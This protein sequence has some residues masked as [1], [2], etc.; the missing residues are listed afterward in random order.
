M[1][2][3]RQLRGIERENA[4]HSLINQS[5]LQFRSSSVL[6]HEGNLNSEKLIENKNLIYI[7]FAEIYRKAKSEESNK[8]THHVHNF[9]DLRKEQ[10]LS[11]ESNATHNA[12]P[13]EEDGDPVRDKFP[14]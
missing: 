9:E 5:A 3:V 11:P 1:K 14:Q 8:G 10:S 2:K 4:K 6:K 13:L 12:V 7:Q